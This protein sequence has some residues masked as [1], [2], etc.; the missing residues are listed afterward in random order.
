MNPAWSPV[1]F[2]WVK[3]K[4]HELSW[5]ELLETEGDTRTH[6]TPI[7]GPCCEA[8]LVPFKKRLH[9]AALNLNSHLTSLRKKKRMKKKKRKTERAGEKGRCKGVKVCRASGKLRVKTSVG[10]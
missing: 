1:F 9:A 5:N 6:K 8:D 10:T 2:S 7:S 3:Q 4:V